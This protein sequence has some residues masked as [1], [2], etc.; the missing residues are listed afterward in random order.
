MAINSTETHESDKDHIIGKVQL[1]GEKE[2][3]TINAMVDLG[4]TEYIIDS[5]VRKKQ[6]I[7]T[8]KTKNPRKIYLAD[9]KPS[10]MGPVTHMTEVPMDISNHRE[11]ATFQV[12]NLQHDEVILRMP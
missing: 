4:A 3:V 9:R 2:T 5:E 10:A 8:T 11:L 6:G 12:G 7:K 1:R